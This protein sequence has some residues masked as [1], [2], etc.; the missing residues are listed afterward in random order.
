MEEKGEGR[1]N[2][3]RGA[4]PIWRHLQQRYKC[5]QIVMSEL[6]LTAHRLGTENVCYL[7]RLKNPTAF[8]CSVLVGKAEYFLKYFNLNYMQYLMLLVHPTEDSKKYK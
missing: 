3:S 8:I 4:L 2:L 5:S 7:F 1:G 6:I